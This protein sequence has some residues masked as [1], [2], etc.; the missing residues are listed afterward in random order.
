MTAERLQGYG[1]EERIGGLELGDRLSAGLLSVHA[2]DGQLGASR[3]RKDAHRVRGIEAEVGGGRDGQRQ[4][5][6]AAGLV[7]RH[8]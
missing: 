2:S 1:D 3:V 6:L 8:A 5:Q 7:R 4:L